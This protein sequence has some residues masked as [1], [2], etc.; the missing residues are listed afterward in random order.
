MHRIYSRTNGMPF[1][2]FGRDVRVSNKI[3]NE[4]NIF[5][6]KSESHHRQ[7]QCTTLVYISYMVIIY[8][9]RTIGLQIMCVRLGMHFSLFYRFM[10]RVLCTFFFLFSG[11][12]RICNTW[13][14]DIYFHSTFAFKMHARN[15]G[16]YPMGA[17]AIGQASVNHMPNASRFRWWP[18][19]DT[20][21]FHIIYAWVS[22]IVSV[23]RWLQAI[24]IALIISY[25]SP[26]YVRNCAVKFGGATTRRDK[27]AHAWYLS[28]MDSI[29]LRTIM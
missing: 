10:E 12:H 15:C 19:R 20:Q 14:S 24:D 16:L 11:V 28:E 29:W 2:F 21:R 1:R 3:K 7:M 23:I 25:H 8:S 9:E 17:W 5:I 26:H 18:I 22:N 6:S 4:Q 27:R 13:Q